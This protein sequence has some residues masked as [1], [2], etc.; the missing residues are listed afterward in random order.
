MKSITVSKALENSHSLI[1]DVV[2]DTAKELSSATFIFKLDD[3]LKSRGLTQKDLASMTGIRV[4]TISEW[5]NGKGLSINKVQ[6]V[7]IMVALR[8]TSINDIIEIRLPVEIHAQ[9]KEEAE[10]WQDTKHM[11]DTIRALFASNVL[12]TAGLK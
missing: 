6:L 3:L 2:L 10:L 5:V 7:A 11:P 12:K 1:N 8:V 4:G 9:Y